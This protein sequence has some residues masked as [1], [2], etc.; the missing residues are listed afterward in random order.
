MTDRAICARQR[1]GDL[2]NVEVF[3]GTLQ[4]APAVAAY[5]VVVVMGVLEY[6]A[7][8]R[9]DPEDYLQFL[10]QAAAFLQ[11]GGTVILG[12]ENPLGVKYLCGAPE[13][14]SGRPFDSV[15]GYGRPGPAR[16]F[17]RSVLESMVRAA[18]LSPSTFGLFPDY[19]LARLAFSDRLL[20]FEP[21]L[22]VQ[23]PHFPSPD[24]AVFAPRVA[25]EAAMSGR[26][27]SR[28]AWGGRAPTHS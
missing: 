20:E 14:H 2:D 12:I 19:K 11:P 8:G 4:G 26:I 13:D 1:T 18:G 25:N 7:E 24:W 21:Q 9:P 22:A 6:V 28:A 16:T 3:I 17:S 27:W 5:D 23:I 10:R 15:E